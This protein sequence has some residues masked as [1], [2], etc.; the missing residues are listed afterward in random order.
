VGNTGTLTAGTGILGN[1]NS[2]TAQQNF[3]VVDSKNIQAVR[4]ADQ[5]S[6]SDIGA[7][8]NAAFTDCSYAC[9][10]VIPAGMYNGVTTS[11]NIPLNNL[12]SATLTIQG[13]V[14]YTGTGYFIDTYETNGSPANPNLSID[15]FG[16]Q[17][18]GT[19]AG[20]GGI[21]L[22]PTNGIKITNPNVR[23]FINGDG[24]AI[25]GSI[26]VSIFGGQI[27]GNKNNVH[28]YGTKC[29]TSSPFTCGPSPTGPVSTYAPNKLNL[30]GTILGNAKQRGLYIDG[31]VSGTGN[32]S[33]VFHIM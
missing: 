29:Q 20:Q 8:A 14:N 6:G 24:I 12:G 5:F 23:D 25:E 11:I 18:V 9:T 13:T 31:S 28:L 32:V 21:H 22:L 17:I 4:Y 19:S 16:G 30:Y 1:Q 3:T 10:V 15:F 27:L 33:A 2:F 7:K 26:L